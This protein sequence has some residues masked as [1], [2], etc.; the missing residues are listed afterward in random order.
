MLPHD[1]CI[2]SE[3]E[4]HPISLRE[5]DELARFRVPEGELPRRPKRD[6]NGGVLGLRTPLV[7]GCRVVVEGLPVRPV[8]VPV[9]ASAPVAGCDGK[10]VADPV[11][12]LVVRSGSC[13]IVAQ[14]MGTLMPRNPLCL[15]SA[16][17]LALPHLFQELVV[18]V[19]VILRTEELWNHNH[20]IVLQWHSVAPPWWCRD[21]THRRPGKIATWDVKLAAEGFRPVLVVIG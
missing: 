7:E 4:Q 20:V 5:V 16:V 1:V 18:H 10:V 21:D 9:E 3:V 8:T 19:P 17:C 2:P 12:H 14:E 6:A 13:R 11:N 15:V